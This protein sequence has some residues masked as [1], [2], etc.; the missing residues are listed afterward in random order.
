MDS[1]PAA[2][3]IVASNLKRHR[4]R[5]GL[6]LV[7]LARASGIAKATLTSIESGSA[8]PTIDTLWSIAEALDIDFAELLAAPERHDDTRVLRID[9]MPD[10]EP[11]G[12]AIRL[13]DRW[14]RGPAEL[15]LMSFATGSTYTSG[16]HGPDVVEHL[17]VLHGTLRCGTPDHTADCEAGDYIRFPAD[18]EHGYAAIDGPA[19]AVLCVNYPSAAAEPR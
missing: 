7:A 6:S 5:R 11:A 19:L 9:D 4:T 17:V 18:R 8:N 13:L 10:P 16:S 3:R 14:R 12:E 15:Y 1:T 2:Q